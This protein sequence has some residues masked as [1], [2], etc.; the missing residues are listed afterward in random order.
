MSDKNVCEATSQEVL[1]FVKMVETIALEDMETM[2]DLL[3][4]MYESVSR[5]V[6]RPKSVRRWTVFAHIVGLSSRNPASVYIYKNAFPYLKLVVAD[7]STLL[8]ICDE[9]VDRLRNSIHNHNLGEFLSG[10]EGQSLQRETLVFSSTSKKTRVTRLHVFFVRE[11]TDYDNARFKTLTRADHGKLLSE[12][13]VQHVLHRIYNRRLYDT[14][15]LGS[16]DDQQRTLVD[17][18]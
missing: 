1:D 3:E 8:S 11:L 10:F 6:E 18:V 5:V 2:H 15:R 14:R 17:C 12:D 4:G 7:T 16:Y 9:T 13:I